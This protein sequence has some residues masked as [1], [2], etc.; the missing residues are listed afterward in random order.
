MTIDAYRPHIEKRSHLSER[1]SKHGRKIDVY[2]NSKHKNYVIT[3][4]GFSNIFVEFRTGEDISSDRLNYLWWKKENGITLRK[5]T[6]LQKIA[7]QANK[8][9]QAVE[10]RERYE[11][12]GSE[13]Y[14]YSIARKHSISL[15]VNHVVR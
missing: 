9:K 13:D 15:G 12:A 8:D 6:D 11:Y 10:E 1:Y 4:K 5:E 7:I 3:K 14:D 2:W